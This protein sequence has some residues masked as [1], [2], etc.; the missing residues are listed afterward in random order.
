MLPKILS[1]AFSVGQQ[2]V[3]T[4]TAT[5]NVFSK[6]MQNLNVPRT[7][8]KF[9]LGDDDETKSSEYSLNSVKKKFETHAD[10]KLC[11]KLDSNTDFISALTQFQDPL[12]GFYSDSV[13]RKMETEL[14][15]K[16]YSRFIELYDHTIFRYFKILKAD[17]LKKLV[18]REI[19]PSVCYIYSLILDVNIIIVDDQT[20]DV[21]SVELKPELE[22]IVLK[23][24]GDEFIEFLGGVQKVEEFISHKINTSATRNEKIQNVLLKK[25]KY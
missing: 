8:I 12:A 10:S 25:N 2:N 18:A 1:N 15:D 24:L 21:C 7:T 16:S 17:I 11:V 14:S 9:V 13:R 5:L 23:K 4:S 6:F 19:H 22:T 3:T 20:Y